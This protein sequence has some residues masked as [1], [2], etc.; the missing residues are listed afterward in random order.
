MT[1]P[2]PARRVRSFAA[3]LLVTFASLVTPALGGPSNADLSIAMIDAPDPVAP[4]K[5]L[6]YRVAVDVKGQRAASNV[7]LQTSVPAGTSFERFVGPSGW[8]LT[9]PPQGWTGTVGATV[10]TLVPGRAAVFQLSVRVAA[11][12]PEGATVSNSATVTS[13]ATD[14][15]PDDNTAVTTTTVRQRRVP[16]ADLSVSADFLQEPAPSFGQLVTMVAVR[17]DGPQAATDVEVRTTTP[18]GTL[19]VSAGSSQG[20]VTGP[21]PGSSGEVVGRIDVIPNGRV[22]VITV[23]VRVTA[24]A[25]ARVETIVAATASSDDPETRNNAAHATARVVEPG[26]IA[27]VAVGF[28]DPPERVLTNADLSYTVAERNDDPTLA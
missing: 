16:T 25:G 28:T 19:F 6:T 10:A 21:A 2:R 23:V 27:D 3:S 20:S 12:T 7:S 8:T 24:A 18:S 14:A 13:A 22:V 1:L 11:D 4:G 5:V 17:N 9:A 15:N 26:P